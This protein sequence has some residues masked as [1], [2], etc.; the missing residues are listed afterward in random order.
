VDSADAAHR[1]LHNLRVSGAPCESVEDVLRRLGAV[2]SQEYPSGKWS[3]AQ[4]LR[5]V[6]DADLDRAFAA[7]QILRT[8]VLRPTWHFVLPEDIRWLVE[9]TGPRVHGMNAYYARQGG[10]DDDALLAG[11]RAIASALGDDVQLTRGEIE[12]VLRQA[13]MALK[14]LTLAYM[15][16]HAELN[17]VICSGAMRGKQHTYALLEARAPNA[18]RLSPDEA[19][20][21]LTRR[22]FSS[23]GPA[24]TNDFRWWSSLSAGQIKR[25]LELID[26]ELEHEVIDGV[27]VWFSGGAY[28][29]DP[30]PTAY[31]LQGYDEYFVGYSGVTKAVLD[32][33]GMARAHMDSK[34]AIFTHVIVL[35]SQVVGRWK[36]TVKKNEVL[37]EADI[38][39]PLDEAQRAAVQNAVDGYAEFLQLPVRMV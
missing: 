14:G 15:I 27:T 36:R 5:G 25:G 19:L 10:L 2:Q 23:H 24:S 17:G 33:S 1:R 3:I 29:R 9:L 35:D 11:Q 34:S 20:A 8:H 7:G 22:Y 30:S 16:M 38:F 37:L 6:S 32:L 28:E 12:A 31:L 21:E 26:G 18:R 13:G 39:V 4:R